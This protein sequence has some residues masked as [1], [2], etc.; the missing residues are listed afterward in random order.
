MVPPRTN[1]QRGERRQELDSRPLSAF[2]DCDAYVLLGDPGAGKTTAFEGEAASLGDEAHFVSARDFL[3]VSTPPGKTLL[4]DGLDEVRA[5]P[6][7]A[8]SKFDEIRRRFDGLGRPRFRLSCREADWLGENDRR[9]LAKVAPSDKLTVLR[10]DPLTEVDIERIL[11]SLNIPNPARF[12]AEVRKRGLGGLL[13][14]PQTLHMLTSAVRDRDDWPDSRRDTFEMACRHIAREHNDEH[15]AAFGSSGLPPPAQLLDA[16]GRLCAVQLLTGKAGFSLDQGDDDGSHLTLDECDYPSPELLRQA[17]GTKLFRGARMPKKTPRE[18]VSGRPGQRDMTRSSP[19]PGRVTPI[20]RHVAEFLAAR[21]LARLVT[22]DKLPAT[23]VVTLMEGD[24]G[25][26]VS[27][28]RG[29]SAWLA[30]LC[31]AARRHLIDRDPV[32]VGLYGDIGGF[33]HAE[34]RTLLEALARESNW[35]DLGFGFASRFAKLATPDMESVFR[36]FLSKPPSEEGKDEFLPR[37][38]LHVLN[39]SQPMSGLSETLLGIVRDAQWRLADRKLALQAYC[40]GR[41]EQHG[42][43]V[44]KGLLKDIHGG[45]VKDPDNDLRGILLEQLYPHA[46]SPRQLWKYCSPPRIPDSIGKYRPF[47]VHGLVAGLKDAP[48]DHVAQHLDYLSQR[49]EAPRSLLRID[50]NRLRLGLVARGLELQ[51]DDLVRCGDI[52]RLYDWLGVAS[53]RDGTPGDPDDPIASIRDWLAE[54]PEVWKDIFSEGL[55]RCPDDDGLRRCRLDLRKRL[56]GSRKPR[57]FGLWCL[58]QA[59]AIEDEM[60]WAAEYL[61]DRA[62]RACKDDHINQDLSLPVIRDRIDHSPRLTEELDR[63]EAKGRASDREDAEWMDESER[64]RMEERNRCLELL[65]SQ[66]D[67]LMENRAP[68]ILLYDYARS[69]FGLNGIVIGA[70]DDIVADPTAGLRAI[71]D[72][73]CGDHALTEAVLAGF[74]GV[75]S[76][77]DLP[78]LEDVVDAYGENRIYYLGLPLLAGLAE[79]ER[80]N[81]EV[82]FPD[83][84]PRLAIAFYFATWHGS[85]KPAWFLRLLE[86]NPEDVANVQ[87]LMAS[88]GFRGGRE[89]GDCKHYQLAFDPKYAAVA[90]ASAIKLLRAFPTQRP[91]TRGRTELTH[92]LIAALK[93]AD[94]GALR[95][96]VESKLSRSSLG[97]WQR[98][99]WLQAGAL[100]WPDTYE[101]DLRGYVGGRGRRLAELT[102]FIFFAAGSTVDRAGHRLAALLVRLLA[103]SVDPRWSRDHSGVYAVTST[104]RRSELVSEGIRLLSS[105]H[106]VEAR[107]ALQELEEEALEEDDKG[108]WAWRH[109]LRKARKAQRVIQRDHGYRHP[110]A[111]DVCRTLRGAE[112]ANVADLWALAKD[113]LKKL[114][115]EIERGDADGWRPFWNE[116]GGKSRAPREPKHEESCRDAIIPLLRARLPDDVTV[117]PEAQHARANRSDLRVSYQGSSG[118]PFHVPVEIKKS[119]NR[120]LWTAIQ[121]QLIAKYSIDPAA[122]GHGVYLVLWFGPENTPKPPDGDRPGS[123]RKLEECLCGTLSPEQSRKISICVIDVSGDAPQP[124]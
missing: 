35:R 51:G 87:V 89:V 86:D 117:A 111:E 123:A 38:L 50:F 47:W 66:V 45:S 80:T 55:R 100:A 39:A 46:L 78:S 93:H 49:S 118:E 3:V 104:M 1:D 95:E 27:E 115:R 74:R 92:L 59:V 101:T 58:D 84:D 99:L 96:V 5:G 113:H 122:N 48:P 34:K 82:Q 64:R 70:F 16:A 42:L 18:A 26:V 9:H 13:E 112:P 41:K 88:A 63:L 97:M 61:L 30:A 68:P 57:D 105:S 109:E 28:L 17:L 22:D 121:N 2:R 71:E 56:Y 120:E 12:V 98:V 32:G 23:R 69:Y 25:T 102:D 11:S 19:P 29:L 106:S 107:K 21:H 81:S 53:Q 10:L 8:R 7:D 124:P 90:R 60:P 40:V 43:E 24:D 33:A 116:E 79:S 62:H 110:N 76:R 31:P 72:R 75:A 52:A 15:R 37:F 94:D 36:D 54:R 85:Y 20:H 114:A 83:L 6:I 119:D 91:R 73:A 108:L 44:L 67:A 4:I 103:G 14:N 65:R 77:K